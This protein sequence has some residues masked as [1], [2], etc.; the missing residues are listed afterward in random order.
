MVEE[1]VAPFLV[2][3]LTT[4]MTLR[5]LKRAPYT[6]KTQNICI[7]QRIIVPLQRKYIEKCNILT[8]KYIEKCNNWTVNYIEKCNIL[9]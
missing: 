1:K 5:T 3:T 2:T 7:I 9:C 8:V 6:K 4:L